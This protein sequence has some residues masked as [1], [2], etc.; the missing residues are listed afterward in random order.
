MAS[1]GPKVSL[2]SMLRGKASCKVFS[3][4]LNTHIR[5][6]ASCDMLK[7]GH[8]NQYFD[9]VKIPRFGQNML[10]LMGTMTHFEK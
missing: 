6:V 7:H 4:L 3:F 2:K 8:G 1:Y 9:T 10:I 5:A